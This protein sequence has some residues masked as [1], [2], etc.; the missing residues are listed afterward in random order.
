MKGTTVTDR[1]PCLVPGCKRTTKATP[2]LR[3]WICPRHWLPLPKAY[4][5]AYARACRQAR[6]GDRAPATIAPLWRT[7]RRRA[8]ETAFMD[9]MV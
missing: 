6:Q 8:I 1:R 3:E 4:R 9:P 7:L 2:T 5:R